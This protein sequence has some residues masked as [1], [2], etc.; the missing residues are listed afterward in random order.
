MEELAAFGIYRIV[1]IETEQKPIRLI[2]YVLF[3][4]LM[5]EPIANSGK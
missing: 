2:S 4:L 3:A 5:F 1:R